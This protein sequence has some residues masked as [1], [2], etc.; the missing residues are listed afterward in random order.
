M[1]FD[2]F[3]SKAAIKSPPHITLHMPFKWKDSKVQKLIEVLDSFKFDQ[4]PFEVELSGFDYFPPKVVFV[5]VIPNKILADLQSRLTKHIRRDL[6]IMNSDYKNRGFHPHITVAFR[7]LK[8]VDFPKAQ[9]RFNQIHYQSRFSAHNIHL[10]KH[11]GTKW[12]VFHTIP[13][14]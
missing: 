5:N 6:Q 8:K 10:L 11:N 12:E 2:L 14:T 4:C 13:A 7:D 3:G 9:T 1:V